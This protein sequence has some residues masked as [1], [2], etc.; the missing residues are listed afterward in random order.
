[1]FGCF[2]DRVARI[3]QRI[4]LGI[5]MKKSR[6]TRYEYSVHVQIIKQLGTAL[7][8]GI[9]SEGVL[10]LASYVTK[11]KLRISFVMDDS[12]SIPRVFSIS[13]S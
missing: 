3:D 2:R 5:Q 11:L 6:D 1:M 4:T 10:N 13:K 8:T 7:Y 9:Y 12:T